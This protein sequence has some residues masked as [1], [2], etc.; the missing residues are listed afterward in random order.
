MTKED[1]WYLQELNYSFTDGFARGY[2]RGFL[3]GMAMVSQARVELAEL[4]KK[5]KLNDEETEA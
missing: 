2:N 3:D 1:K 4:V 5:E